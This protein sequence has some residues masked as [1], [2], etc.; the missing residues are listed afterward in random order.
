MIFDNFGGQKSRFLD[1]FKVVLN[2]FGKCLGFIFGLKKPI[3]EC[4]FS[5]IGPTMN[6]KI[7]FD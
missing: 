1:F 2:L 7:E 4:I 6:P 5:S 3:S